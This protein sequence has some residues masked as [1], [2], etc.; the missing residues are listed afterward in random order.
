MR[1]M[2]DRRKAVHLY[3]RGQ[4]VQAYPQ[5]PLKPAHPTIHHRTLTR[6]HADRTNHG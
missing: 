5:A 4:E 6:L 2:A 3:A 1:H